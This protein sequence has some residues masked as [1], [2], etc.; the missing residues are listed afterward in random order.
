[1]H[2][3][4]SVATVFL[5]L[6]TVGPNISANLPTPWVGLLERINIGVALAPLR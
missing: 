4:L 1:M 3:V 2:I 5:F 6:L